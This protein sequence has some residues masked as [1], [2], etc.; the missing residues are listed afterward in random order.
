MAGKHAVAQCVAGVCTK[1]SA[2]ES[3][4]VSGRQ[5]RI[6]SRFQFQT[7]WCYCAALKSLEGMLELEIGEK[8]ITK[9]VPLLCNFVP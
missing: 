1:L 6:T 3:S 8:V 2:A 5:T 7:S 9:L 4:S